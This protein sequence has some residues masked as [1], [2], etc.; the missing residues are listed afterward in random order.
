[1]GTVLFLCTGNYYRSRF[2][3]ELFNARAAGA[4]LAWRAYSRAL[5]I[6]R[7]NNNVGAMSPL[8]RSA[9][10]ELNV[11]PAAG[12]RF[13]LSCTPADLESADLIVALS[14]AE[15]RPLMSDRYAAWHVQTEFWDVEDV[16]VTAPTVALA[17]IR[18]RVEA[19]I[20]RLASQTEG[21]V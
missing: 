7:G 16:G 4:D 11:V 21:S 19:L 3:E 13:P 5:A 6:E 20:T 18:A 1:M 14:D 12:E 2:A 8:V 17:A 9:L 10:A 15:H